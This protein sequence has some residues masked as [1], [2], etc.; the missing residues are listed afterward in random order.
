MLI[1]E[2]EG[3]PEGA[4]LARGLA[5]VAP[6]EWLMLACAVATV[7]FHSYLIFSG[8]I[9]NLITRPIHLLLAIPWIFIFAPA[10]SAVAR[11]TG[12]ALAVLG[13]A[14]AL[15]I[16]LAREELADQYGVLE[17]PLQYAVALLLIVTVLE[18]ARRAIKWVLPAIAVLVLLYGYFGWLI[19]GQFGHAGL[20]LGYFLGTLVIAEG[21]LWSSLTGLSAEV[22]APFVILGAF[23]SAGAA[24]TGFMALAV[25]LAGRYR[26][27]AAKVSVLA[28]AMYGTIS[29][30]AAANTASTGM[31]TIPAMKR[32]GYPPALAAA[33]EAVASTGGQIMPPIMGA[34]VF[35]MAEL[36]RTSYQSLMVAAAL[37]AF[38]FFAT[39]WFGVHQFAIRHGL[40]GLSREELPGWPL[41][42][43]TLPF[44]LLPF[45]LLVWFLAFTGYTAPY[46]A[47]FATWL[48]AALLLMDAKG[49]LRLGRWVMRLW[50]ACL[51][52]GRQ[53]AA[54][55][56]IIIC[57]SLI[58]GVFHMTGLGVKITSIIISAAGGNLWVALLLTGLASLILGMELPT[59][60]AYIICVAVAGPALVELGLPELYA[61]FF[62]FW[63]ALLCTITP[64]VCGNVFIAAGIARTPWLPVAWR[65]MQ[66]GIGLFLVP[67]GFV[68]NP[69]LLQLAAEPFLA[70][71]AMLKVGLGV[72]LLSF[73]AIDPLRRAWLRP[74][75]VV[76]GL[77]ALF[78]LPVG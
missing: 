44:F 24:G 75:A 62:V 28:S 11:V 35:V 31:V 15:Y 74:L 68:A 58:V 41:V 59:T 37:P 2:E 17:G 56:A 47:G 69:A 6:R 5:S 13:A 66:L 33:V 50:S 18:M 52:A 4:P 54:I 53:I 43:R 76:A 45:G 40:R 30:T 73:A 32:L 42:I 7:A 48:T 8:L 22:V 12:W 55:A 77:M 38:L 78:L 67:L 72:W 19:P 25:Q 61:H 46:A 10:G 27:G 51:E 65:A 49:R 14:S 20:P 9:P 3:A 29:G 1:R 34:A 21:G 64:P 39:A 26:A 63:Y 36:L 60:A 16:V 70:L 71:L 57:A 23:I